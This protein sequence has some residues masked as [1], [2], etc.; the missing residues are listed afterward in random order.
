MGTRPR[1]G[2]G[3]HAGLHQPGSRPIVVPLALYETPLLFSGLLDHEGTV[4][5][6]NQ[7]SIEGCGLD[8]S[9]TVG[10]PFWEGGWWSPDPDLAARIQRWCRQSLQSGDSLRATTPYFLGDSEPFAWSIWLCIRCSIVGRPPDRPTH[11]GHRSRCD[12]TP[13]PPERTREERL[14]VEANALESRGGGTGP[15]E[16]Q[17]LQ[18]S[19]HFI[20]DRLGR[21]ASA[22]IDMVS[23]ESFEELTRLVF[24]KAF[25]ILGVDGG[26]LV[27]RDND[28]LR[29]FLSDRLREEQARAKYEEA[30]FDSPWPGRHVARTGER[31]IFPTREGRYRL[32]AG[33]G[34]GLRG[35]GSPGLG[36]RAIEGQRSAVGIHGGLV[37]RGTG[38]R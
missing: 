7:V 10:H 1:V 8:R 18:D 13:S 20:R 9:E 32:P 14:A 16:L 24:D 2:L 22:A 30:P 15:A 25:P 38:D 29:V 27:I 34:P 35:H 21:L 12:Q 28:E 3:H 23:V 17:L 6:G 36:V 31:L 26:A 37:A 33:D 19:E 4:L 11:R 5:E